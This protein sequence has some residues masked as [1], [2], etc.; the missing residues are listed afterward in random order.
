[1]KITLALMPFNGKQKHANNKLSGIMSD[2]IKVVRQ[3][4]INK[5]TITVTS[6]FIN[7]IN[8]LMHRKLIA[9]CV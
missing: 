3:A 9:G 1:M 2:T 8:R 4:A 7:K 5:N 6:R